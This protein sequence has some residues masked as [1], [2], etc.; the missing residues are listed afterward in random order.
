MT[1]VI[2]QELIEI[3]PESALD[4]FTKPGGVEPYLNK[5]RIQLDA[6]V[7]IMDTKDGR[8]EIR[9]IAAKVAKSKTYLDGV[10]KA[11]NDEQKEV[12][13]KIDAARKLVRDTLDKW[14][15]E[16]RQPLTDWEEAEARRVEKHAIKIE[17]ITYDAKIHV[18]LRSGY[19]RDRIARV[20]AVVVG[21]ECEEFEDEYARV[22][23]AT[24]SSL[25]EALVR[26]E[27]YEAEQAELAAL[28]KASE[29][30]AARDRD[31]EIRKNA[32]AQAIAQAEAKAK[33]DRDRFENE[34]KAERDAAD[35]RELALKQAAEDAE[36]RA[37]DAADG[38]KREQE[39]KI[40]HEKAEADRREANKQHCA[41]VNRAAVKGFV[42][43]G[44][45]EDLARAVVTLIAR[46]AI[47]HIS[48]S[49]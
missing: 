45:A 49:Y 9:S 39:A 18:D 35:R 41:A 31:E 8:D 7:P 17:A 10:G 23:D 1:V 28:R 33:A 46:K 6:F 44:I 34:A 37:I 2:S 4:V 47:P 5:I 40:A 36:R 22:K 21:S 42:D 32:A 38:A 25:R 20:E 29:E 26:A 48:I 13:K 30:R 19:I 14:R 12:P 43:G 16:V 11:L 15:D 3:R 24:L 27:K